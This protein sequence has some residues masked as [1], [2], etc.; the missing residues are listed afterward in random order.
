MTTNLRLVVNQPDALVNQVPKAQ[1]IAVANLVPNPF[2]KLAGNDANVVKAPFSKTSLAMVVVL[3]LAAMALLVNAK[4]TPPEVKEPAPMMVSLVSNP[5]P[6][7]EIVPLVPPPPKPK[8]VI[9]K[10]KPIVKKEL[11]TPEP[12]VVEQAAVEPVVVSEAPPAPAAPVVQAKPVEVPKAPEPEPVIEPP[13]FGA[14]YLHNP[15]PDYPSSSRRLGE[16]GRVLLK[17]LVSS[18]GDADTVQLEDSSGFERLDTAAIQ[19]VKKWRFIPAKRNNQ[20]ISGYVLVPV[21]FS[22]ES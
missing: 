6:E 20:S 15:P 18:K 22:L 1:G 8:P 7:P 10:Q 2:Y 19:A 17:V 16:E 12:V 4:I 11:P 9:K 3:H 14:A 5:A 21:K 13:R